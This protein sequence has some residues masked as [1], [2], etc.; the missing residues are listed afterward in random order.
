MEEIVDAARECR[1]A[2][3][4]RS[5]LGSYLADMSRLSTIRGSL[6]LCK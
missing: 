3:D 1:I 2:R 4:R 5:D 6:S